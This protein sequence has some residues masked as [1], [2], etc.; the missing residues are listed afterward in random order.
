SYLY[1]LRWLPGGRYVLAIGADLKGRSGVFQIDAQTGDVSPVRLD[2]SGQ[3]LRYFSLS[4]DG[5]SLYSTYFVPGGSV[6]FQGCLCSGVE[7]ELLRRPSLVAEP[8]SPDGQYI[9]LL[10]V[11]P[12]SNS[13]VKLLLPTAGGEPRELMR[14]PSANGPISASWAPDSRSF[15]TLKLTG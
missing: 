10:C 11:D 1:S 15:F 5:R 7:K 13:G 12:S 3:R 6:I 8:V 9:A 14:V 2:Q 4:P